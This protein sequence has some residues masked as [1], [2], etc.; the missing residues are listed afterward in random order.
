MKMSHTWQWQTWQGLPYLTCSLLNDWQHGFFTRQFAPQGPT[1]LVQVLHPQANAYWVKQVHG[2]Q[3]LSPSQIELARATAKAGSEEDSV[4][5]IPPEADGV[6]SDAPQQSVWSCTADCTPVLIADQAS[7]HVAAIHAGWRGTAAKIVSLAVQ[8]LQA[9]GSQ[10]AD[11]L[12][13]MGPAISGQI[14]QVSTAVAAAVGNSIE[15]ATGE[16]SIP[17]TSD[18]T[19]LAP[20]HI[21]AVLEKLWQHPKPPIYRDTKPGHVYLDVR[22][23]IALQLEQLG[24]NPEQ[25]AVA[26][27]CTYQDPQNFFSYRRESRRQVQW[28]GIVSQNR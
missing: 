1:N 12:V 6:Y 9:Q 27:H 14:Y 11:L 19:V 22:Q 28:S 24:L 4:E 13:A 8:K 23:V 15:F 17:A 21:E 10:T 5:P 16:L 26:P 7:G 25:I 18:P 2:N 3:L 20:E